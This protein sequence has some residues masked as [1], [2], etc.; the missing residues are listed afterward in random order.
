MQTN[1][2]TA[3]TVAA[4]LK[5]QA[6]RFAALPNTVKMVDARAIAFADLS[7]AFQVLAIH[8]SATIAKNDKTAARKYLARATL[9]SE[10]ITLLANHSEAR[11]VA[12]ALLDGQKALIAA[13]AEFTAHIDAL[14]TANRATVCA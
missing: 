9:C 14:L 7:S 6:T 2:K 11:P 4:M 1:I 8:L 12:L 10:A 5:S 3:S 13:H